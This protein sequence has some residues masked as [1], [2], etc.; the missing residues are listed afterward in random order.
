MMP[1]AN[2]LLALTG[3]IAAIPTTT[4]SQ[5]TA[6]SGQLTYTGRGVVC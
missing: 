5:R 6:T 1:L 3:S 2:V 4:L